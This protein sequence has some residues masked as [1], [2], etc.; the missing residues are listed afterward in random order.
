MN[1]SEN[2]SFYKVNSPNAETL[3]VSFAGHDKMF[4]RIQRFEF[5]HFIDKNFKHVSRHFYVD[6]HLCSYHKGL[7][8]LTNSIDETAD[9]LKNEIKNYKNVIFLGVSS[10]GYAAILFGSLLNVTSV[11][12]F[13]PQ[14]ILR[15][16]SMDEKYRDLKKI[17]NGTTN[18]YVYGDLSVRDVMDYHHISHCERIA[19]H[20]NVFLTKKEHINVKEMRDNGELYVIV[21]KLITT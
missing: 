21:N 18:Y 10:G 5:V 11:L 19:H 17:I 12:A 6:K 7:D 20:S 8:K 2:E 3:I 1:I 16:T 14:T 4:G 13:I 9:Y 15:N